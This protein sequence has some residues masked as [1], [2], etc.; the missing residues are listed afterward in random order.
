M[1]TRC[2]ISVIQINIHQHICISL[3]PILISLVLFCSSGWNCQI[4]PVFLGAM[5]IHQLRN[6]IWSHRP[7]KANMASDTKH[8]MPPGWSRKLRSSECWRYPPKPGWKDVVETSLELCFSVKNIQFASVLHRFLTEDEFR[9][10]NFM[11]FPNTYST[12]CIYIY[13]C[14]IYIYIHIILINVN[15]MVHFT[16]EIIKWYHAVIM[17]FLI[18]RLDGL[19]RKK[20]HGPSNA[21]RIPGVGSSAVQRLPN[22]KTFGSFAKIGGKGPQNGWFNGK[23]YLNGWFGGKTPYFWKHPF[24]F[25]AKKFEFKDGTTKSGSFFRSF[26][27]RWSHQF[28]PILGPHDLGQIDENVR[29]PMQ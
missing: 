1:Y 26:Q 29:N 14:I 4:S 5:F 8:K 24:L 25:L 23:P 27:Y 3:F 12:M 2:V 9:C 17:R 21:H 28:P 10:Q 19:S 16:A 15:D 22:V 18:M 20:I 7:K 11:M 13:V 6:T